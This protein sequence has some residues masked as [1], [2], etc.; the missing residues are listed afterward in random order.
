MVVMVMVVMTDVDGPRGR[1][2][3][4]G[5]NHDLWEGIKFK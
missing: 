5:E 4:S 1:S 2:D 3:D